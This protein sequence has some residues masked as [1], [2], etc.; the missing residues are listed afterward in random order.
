MRD[1]NGAVEDA[2]EANPVFENLVDLHYGVV[3]F[4]A[5]AVRHVVD[6]EYYLRH[7]QFSALLPLLNSDSIQKPL[8]STKIFEILFLY[9]K[10]ESG[11]MIEDEHLLE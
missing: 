7:L 8:P 9:F 10:V 6:M 11:E 1:L 4:V 3:G 5:A 2:T